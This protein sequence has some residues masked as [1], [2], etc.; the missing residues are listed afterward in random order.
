MFRRV[1]RGA[2]AA[3]AVAGLAA[4]C[5]TDLGDDGASGS[6]L[7]GSRS[8]TAEPGRYS[9]LPEP[10]GTVDEDTL[11]ELLP[12]GEP[13]AYEGEPTATYDTGRRV[14]CEWN[15]PQ[16]TTA[17][18]LTVDFQRV[19]SYDPGI[20]DDDQAELDFAAMAAEAGVALDDTATATVTQPGE[21][22]TAAAVDDVGHA[23]YLVD[24]P[25]PGDTGAGREVTV[26]FRSANVIVTV[27]YT[28]A[29][30]R[31]DDPPDS[32]GLQAGARAAARQI[33]G[34]LDG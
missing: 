22:V 14:G 5:S 21:D 13:A 7:T 30:T 1:T 2:A 28:V 16:E 26:A 34:G 15:V 4:G 24:Q 12:G 20:S 11:H 6:G 18:R 8:A 33:A 32:A 25:T 31:A 10:C 23:A 29:T 17:R 19:L 3:L 27:T 9:A